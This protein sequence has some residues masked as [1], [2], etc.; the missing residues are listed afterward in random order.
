[1]DY[2]T[3]ELYDSGRYHPPKLRC[4]TLEGIEEFNLQ[5]QN[6]LTR[7][8]HRRDHSEYYNNNRYNA[9]NRLNLI[10]F[11][12]ARGQEYVHDSSYTEME[13]DTS[14]RD[15]DR[16]RREQRTR[17]AREL[18]MGYR[19]KDAQKDVQVLPPD[20]TRRFNTDNEVTRSYLVK[21]CL[22]KKPDPVELADNLSRRRFHA[23]PWRRVDMVRNDV[24]SVEDLP[25]P[26]RYF[27]ANNKSTRPIK[28]QG[29]Q[30]NL[31]SLHKSVTVPAEREVVNVPRQHC[32]KNT[33]V[34]QV[35]DHIP[36]DFGKA[37]E[38]TTYKKKNKPIVKTGMSHF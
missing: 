36:R 6:P 19:R 30:R 1:M 2:L 5:M 27:L 17:R 9:K 16:K 18:L 33:G 25:A 8:A 37:P 38:Y 13:N 11:G 22:S 21:R 3:E 34:A 12:S 14:F 7:V 31:T 4:Q 10:E 15:D 26:Q 23:S 20:A 29:S 28:S 35:V 32:K 24:I